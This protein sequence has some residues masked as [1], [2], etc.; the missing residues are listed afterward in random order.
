MLASPYN[1]HFRISFWGEKRFEDPKDPVKNG[2]D[3]DEEFPVLKSEGAIRGMSM[4]GGWVITD[5]EF[6]V[7]TL[8]NAANLRSCVLGIGIPLPQAHAIIVYS[9]IKFKP[10]FIWRLP[11][12]L[13]MDLDH[14][15]NF[16]EIE[17]C[18]TLFHQSYAPSSEEQPL[19]IRWT[20]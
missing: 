14:I 19:C 3:V 13:T 18:D 17:S 20:A 7:V 6:W 9:I 2:G 10:L 12:L 15:I 4:G 16:R 1:F 5:Q 11:V 8:E